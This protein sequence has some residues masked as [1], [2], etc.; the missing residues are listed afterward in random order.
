VILTVFVVLLFLSLTGVALGYT[1]KEPYF[2]F[3]G[4]LF[5]F[6]LGLVIMA[7]DVE[8]KTGEEFSSCNYEE[9]FVYG[10]NYSGYHWDYDINDVPT[11]ANPNDF[12][13]V[14]LFHTHRVYNSSCVETVSYVY[15]NLDASYR[16]TVWWFGFLLSLV[17]GFGAFALFWNLKNSYQR[18]ME[19]AK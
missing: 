19:A 2:T 5:L 3:V 6:F 13:C 10:N 15:T 18:S 1:T 17:S 7:G 11:C 16:T 8:Y 12:E 9:F 14:R 4:L